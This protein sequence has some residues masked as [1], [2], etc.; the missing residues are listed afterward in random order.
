MIDI[1]ATAIVAV[2]AAGVMVWQYG[3]LQREKTAHA[4]TRAAHAR[5][6]EDLE[7]RTSTAAQKALA[8]Q[9]ALNEAVAAVDAAGRARLKE[10][11]DGIAKLA[12][13]VGSGGKRLLVR[14]ACPAAAAPADV[15]R[16]PAAPGV[17]DG[18][19]AEL[20]PAA[21]QDYFALLIGLEKQREMIVSLQALARRGCQAAQP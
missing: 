12:D 3:A 15:P 21:R 13:D 7:R 6:L 2:L 18:G 8:F 16:A 20:A 4:E 9:Q 11:E 17:A 1:R 14:A 19:T 10:K 5:V